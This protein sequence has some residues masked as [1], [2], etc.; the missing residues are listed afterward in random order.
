MSQLLATYNISQTAEK[1]VN[2]EILYAAI[3]A[4]SS[5]S[6]FTA[7]ST[8]TSDGRI[9]IW[10]GS[11]ASQAGLDAVIAAHAGPSSVP[12]LVSPRQI[13]LA[14]ITSGI[15][16]SSIDAI[17]DTLPEPD[18]SL[19]KVSWEFAI[20]IDRLDPLIA[21]VGGALELTEQQVDD[22]FKLAITFP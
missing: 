4:S 9:F 21:Q 22:I 12:Q 10:G 15:P 17:M 7:A 3:I 20:E 14:L 6:D 11:I 16:L 2:S 5:V 19:A 1:K 18:K 8:D 13:R